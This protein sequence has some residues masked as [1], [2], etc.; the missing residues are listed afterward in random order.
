MVN[1]AQVVDAIVA[2]L[3]DIPELVTEMGA[4]PAAPMPY[5][6]DTS[7]VAVNNLQN[8]AGSANRRE[9]PNLPPPPNTGGD[10]YETLAVRWSSINAQAAMVYCPAYGPEEPEV[11]AT[12]INNAGSIIGND[13]EANNFASRMFLWKQ[14]TN[15]LVAVALPA[16]T[17]QITYKWG[18]AE[19]LSD[20]HRVVGTAITNTL[21]RAFIWNGTS[22]NA[23][24]IG[25]FSGGAWSNAHDLNEEQMVVGE[26]QAFRKFSLSGTSHSIAYQA[27]YIWHPHFGLKALPAL[28]SGG[29]VPRSCNATAINNRKTSGLVQVAGHC[30][31]NDGRL[32]AV[33]WDIVVQKRLLDFAI[34]P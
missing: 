20:G 18:T 17:A 34:S 7:A 12:D 14:A 11:T 31:G 9:D 28:S 4:N 1:I 21:P 5:K 19:G 24:D 2:K 6:W 13:G 25:T 30:L 27:A 32:H 10:C 15:Q 8:V 26:A 29:L 16:N 33:R 3:R 23:Q 22:A